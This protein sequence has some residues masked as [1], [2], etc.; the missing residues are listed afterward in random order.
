MPG[1]RSTRFRLAS[2]AVKANVR[3]GVAA[4]PG[5]ASREQI[6]IREFNAISSEGEFLWR[7]I[8][9]APDTWDFTG[10]DKFIAFAEQH[11]LYT[12]LTHFVW[13]Q[14]DIWSQVPRWVHDIND[15]EELKSVMRSTSGAKGPSRPESC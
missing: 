8:H 1:F 4:A 3:V 10:A 2:Y 14:K 9:P 12:T 11:K 7:V 6:V 13:D 15:P 5:D